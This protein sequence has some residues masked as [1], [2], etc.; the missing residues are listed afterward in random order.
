MRNVAPKDGYLVYADTGEKVVF[1]ECDPK[2]N[3]ACSKTMCRAEEPE[4]EGGFG[5]CSKTTD[6]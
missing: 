6:P 1:Y 2:K 4:D 5:F 3:T